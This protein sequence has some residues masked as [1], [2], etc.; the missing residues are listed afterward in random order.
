MSKRERA[1]EVMAELLQEPY[2][3]G[4]PRALPPDTAP[5]QT[6]DAVPPPTH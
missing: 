4:P 3:A 2:G 6:A 1:H 5:C